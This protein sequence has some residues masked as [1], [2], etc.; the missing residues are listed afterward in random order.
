[1]FSGRRCSRICECRIHRLRT[2]YSFVPSPYISCYRPQTNLRKGNVFTSVCLE[3][4]PR[5]VYT[6]PRQT[7]PREDT[8]LASTCWDTHT[9]YPVHAGI[10]STRGR[11][12]SHW[13]A[14][15][16]ENFVTDDSRLILL[17][18]YFSVIC[19]E[20]EIVLCRTSGTWRMHWY[21][22][23]D[24]RFESH[25]VPYICVKYTDQNGSAAM[26][27]A[28]TS[29]RHIRGESEESIA[30]RQWSTQADVTRSSKRGYQGPPKG[31]RSSKIKKVLLFFFL[32]KEIYRNL[33]FLL[34]Q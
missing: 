6:A 13:N 2:Y 17:L 21:G 26:L 24:P 23:L 4:C 8:P 29:A 5:G 1:M 34:F 7:P 31:L 16:F 18:L 3:F 19:K 14:F 27:A 30:Q 25:Q 11:Y 9:P 32:K 20:T 28:K 12:A 22:L 33:F 10:P 15:L